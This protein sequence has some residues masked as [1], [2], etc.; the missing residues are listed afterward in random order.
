MKATKTSSNIR[1]IPNNHIP[2]LA[3]KINPKI[4]CP[5]HILANSRKHRVIGRAEMDTSSIMHKKG[6]KSI[7][8]PKGN[9][10]EKL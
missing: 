1:G 6:L 2:Q 8:D 4:T 3:L 7:G 10:K 9:K 5:A